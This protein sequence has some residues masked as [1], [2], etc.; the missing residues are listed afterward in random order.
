MEFPENFKFG[1]SQSGFQFEMGGGSPLDPNSDWFKW[2]HDKEN[3]VSGTVSGDLPEDGVGYLRNYAFLHKEARRMGLNTV[4][5]G[6]EWSRLFPEKGKFNE[7]V[8]SSYREVL[9]DLKDNGFHVILNLY[10]WSMPLWLHD[11]VMVRKGKFEKSG[12]LM[13]DTLDHFQEFVETSVKSLDD[14]VDEYV[15]VNEPNVIWKAGFVLVRMGFPPSYLDFEK[16]EVVKSNLIKACNLAYKSIK[17]ITKKKVGVVFAMADIQGDEE[18]KEKAKVEEEFSFLDNV[19]WDWLGVNYYTRIVVEPLEEGFTVR[20]GLGMYAQ[21]Y[22]ISL[23]GRE[24]SD[25]GWEVYPEGI[26]NVLLESWRRYGKEIYVTENGVS[27]SRDRIRPWYIVSHL[28]FVKKAMDE[29]VPVKGYLHWSL[30]DNYEWSSG[31][32]QRFGLL[33]MN[34]KTRK[35]WW[36]PSAYLYKEIVKAKE[37]D[38]MMLN[39]LN[40]PDLN[41]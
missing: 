3:I 31:F 5:V 25:N 36:R 29:G 10:H 14:L 27:D 2:V 23:D 22:Q 15:I 30:V 40:L 35:T 6:I 1:W 37:I 12:W 21:G 41:G 4:R 13:D 8:A 28:Y 9:K 19:K 24:V 38:E 17:G 16:A 26:K 11:P 20:R 32:S 34:F 18:V 39:Y 7:G 33:G